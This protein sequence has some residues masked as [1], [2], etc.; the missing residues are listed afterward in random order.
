M[1]ARI[2]VCVVTCALLYS[3]VGCSGAKKEVAEDPNA[4]PFVTCKI[5]LNGKDIENAVVELVGDRSADRKVKGVY[6][7]ESEVYKF[8]T[9]EGKERRGGVAAG[10]YAVSVKPGP[11]TKSKIPAK[12][13]DAAKSGLRI[14]VK[15]GRNNLPPIEL[16]S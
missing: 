15:P 4:L 13:A 8:V 3:V 12:Y 2:Q 10:E 5:Q 6:D 14:E 16:A 7:P 1:N 9:L 11:S